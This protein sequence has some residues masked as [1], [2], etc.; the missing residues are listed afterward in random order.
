[1]AGKST[2]NR[3]EQTPAG[4]HDRY[5]RMR[6]DAGKL[7]RL[8]VDLFLESYAHPPRQIILDLDATDDPV[9]GTQEGRF[10]HG[11]HGHYCFL[12]LYLF[13]QEHLLLARLRPS[14]LEASAGTVEELTPILEQIW[15]RWPQVQIVLRAD[16]GFAREEILA[17]REAN[18]TDY[19]FG[20]AKNSR[21]IRQLAPESKRTRKQF[22]QT[23]RAAP[24]FRDFSY[25]TLDSWSRSRR[26]VGKA[27][28][29]EKGSNPCFV[30][31]SLRKV[32]P[33]ALYEDLDCAHGEME[34]RI[35]E[36]QL[37]LFADRTSA[38]SMRSNQ[39]R[40][41]FSSL[42][43]VLLHHLRRVGLHGTELAPAQC[44]TIRT[45]LLKIGALVSVSLRRIRL[46]MASGYP[47]AQLFA[48][49]PDN[50]RQGLSPG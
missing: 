1:L 26:V 39:L 30:V 7:D 25:R 16:S 13:C 14:N 21:W 2:L 31:T 24:C 46:R 29:L 6:Y 23:G 10:F 15:G 11:Y 41:Y 4:D 12:P 5:R 35:K 20:L 36:Q 38:A 3:L 33:K 9:R 49:V 43:D 42:A 45:K 34:N 22:D 40:L 8:L 48:R 47:W 32:P 37:D 50:L 27:E 19:V 17:W 44:G 18:G 28:R